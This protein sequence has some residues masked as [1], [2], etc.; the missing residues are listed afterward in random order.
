MY[1]NE[2]RTD[3]TVVRLT[4]E[5]FERKIG[6]SHEKMNSKWR[7]RWQ[8]QKKSQTSART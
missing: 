1:L 5:Q 6:R 4:A 8:V 2:N 7:G 3:Q